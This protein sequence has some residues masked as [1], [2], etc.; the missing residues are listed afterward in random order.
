MTT[1]RENHTGWK[2]IEVVFV[3]PGVPHPQWREALGKQRMGETRSTH[4]FLQLIDLINRRQWDDRSIH[5]TYFWRDGNWHLAS[6]SL[7]VGLNLRCREVLPGDIEVMDLS[8]EP[9]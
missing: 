5:G 9:A 4:R 3:S 6:E 7:L 1:D 8:D 2:Y